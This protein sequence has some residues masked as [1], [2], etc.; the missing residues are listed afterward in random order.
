MK[1]LL[2]I[3]IIF[4]HY[5]DS[6]YLRYTLKS[7]RIFN[8]KTRIILLGDNL[9]QHYINLNIEHFFFDK[10]S[11]SSEILLFKKVYKFIA[12]NKHGKTEW[13]QFVFQRWFH[14]YEFIKSEKIEQFWTFDSDNLIFTDLQK[15]V[16]LLSD[17]DCT[18]QCNGSCVNGYV[19]SPKIVKGYIDTI[20]NLFVDS[21][22][23][24]KQIQEFVDYPDY[25]F[26]E[27][28]AYYEYRK[29]NNLN[30][31]RLQ[32]I[33]KDETFDECFCQEHG[34]EFVNGKKKL[35]FKE[36]IFYQINKLDQKPVKV[37]TINMSWTKLY[38]TEEIFTYIVNNYLDLFPKNYLVILCITRFKYYLL[39]LIPNIKKLFINL[40]L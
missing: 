11:N 13:T 39:K 35:Y 34:M 27:M 37:N 6:D 31:I 20:N 36:G 10:Y 1:D 18:E 21:N 4:I 30:S 32:N 40:N 24:E 16:S 29:T 28:R 3:P 23:L 12:G 22:Y 14:I 7:A 38:L 19:S 25:A 8:P 5:G 33:S 2:Y 15:Y 26:T 17:Y 9:N